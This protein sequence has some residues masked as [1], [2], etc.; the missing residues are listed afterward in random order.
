MWR[1]EY[2]AK[3]CFRAV[4][5]YYDLT[6]SLSLPEWEVLADGERQEYLDMVGGY[7]NN[8][9]ISAQAMYA[10]G[11]ASRVAAGLPVGDPSLNNLPSQEQVKYKLAHGIATAVFD[12]L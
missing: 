7:Y 2:V 3:I 1:I 12:T 4:K 8:P 5:S 6:M 9:N 10:L 11:R